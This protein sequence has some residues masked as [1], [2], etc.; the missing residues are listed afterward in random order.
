MVVSLFC[1]FALVAVTVTESATQVRLNSTK[2]T[3]ESVQQTENKSCMGKGQKK[4]TTVVSLFCFF[5]L[6]VVTTHQHI[7][8]QTAP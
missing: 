8:G 3:L 2:H 4:L 6:V 5:A 7:I 1:L